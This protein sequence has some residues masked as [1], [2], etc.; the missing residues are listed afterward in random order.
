MTTDATGT[1]L[2]EDREERSEPT[3]GIL[4]YS[5][6]THAPAGGNPAGVV[7]D[8]SA[9]D[10]TRMRAIAAEVGYSETAFVTG[11]DVARRRFG[12]RYFSPLAEVA[13]C[14]HAT[15]ALAVALAER[16][17]P[18]EIVLDTPAGEIPVSTTA[19]GT[20]AVR[21]TLTSVPTRS[22]PALASELEPAL[23]ELGWAPT[24]LDPAL[25]AH[26]AFGGNDHLVLAAASRARLADLDYDFDALAEV[27]RRHGWTT[28]DLVWRESADRFHARNPFP[29]GGVVEDPATG[30]AAAAFGGY[31]RE[32][33]LVPRP[34]TI[35]IRQGEDMGRPSDLLIDVSPRDPRTRVTG[36]AVPIP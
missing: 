3:T 26:V 13:F 27:M 19:D 20:G 1:S 35:A 36:Q 14:G 11:G 33:G 9:L 29:V 31:L 8:A 23:G 22:R 30:A 2:V 32:L 17:G 5:A 10:A 7:L 12:V 18:G 25:P 16:L 34:G 24:D 28:V 15:V 6:F 21:A 4:R